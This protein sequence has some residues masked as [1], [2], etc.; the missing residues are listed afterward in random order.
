MAIPPPAAQLLPLL[1]L[2][3][4]LLVL[5]AL[6]VSHHGCSCFLLQSFLFSVSSSCRMGDD[7]K[8]QTTTLMTMTTT[9][10]ADIMQCSA[11]L[12]LL[13]LLSSTSGG[14]HVASF[15]S[16][17]SSTAAPDDDDDD[18]PDSVGIY[19]CHH[20]YCGNN[21]KATRVLRRCALR[22]ATINLG[23]GIV[24]CHQ[25][26]FPQLHCGCCGCCFL[27]V[28]VGCHGCIIISRCCV[29]ISHGCIVIVVVGCCSCNVVS[30][31]C[32]MA[33][34]VALLFPAA[35]SSFPVVATWLLQSLC[36]PIV[37][38][39]CICIASC[40]CV[41]I[42]C[43]CVVVIALLCHAVVVGCHCLWLFPMVASLFPALG[44]SFPIVALCCCSHCALR[45]WLVVT[46]G[47][48]S[49][50]VLSLFVFSFID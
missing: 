10:K 48:S 39:C 32:I 36:L 29:V 21:H 43:S 31:G 17:L 20:C 3:S 28:V 30:H 44:W 18:A 1:N 11:A 33:V 26:L 9:T 8:P 45:L 27:V 15:L 2:S 42:S 6:D 23:N 13:L 47:H 50:V 49:V 19:C 4:L 40:S 7:K 35:A 37:V 24:A 34:A 16:S 22:G 25:W 5:A 38:G 41:I 12:L 14:I 46:I